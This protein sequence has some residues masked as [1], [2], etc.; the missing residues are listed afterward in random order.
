MKQCHFNTNASMW[1]KQVKVN[2]TVM[3]AVGEY[4]TKL[5]NCWFEEDI[6]LSS[7]FDIS[8]QGK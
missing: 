8:F 4:Q 1:P 3:I 7:H 6:F 2:N 5:G